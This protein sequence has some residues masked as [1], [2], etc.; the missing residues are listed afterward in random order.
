MR[1]DTVNSYYLLLINLNNIF[2][3]YAQL[4]KIFIINEYN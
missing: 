2:G 1:K 4:T 3:N